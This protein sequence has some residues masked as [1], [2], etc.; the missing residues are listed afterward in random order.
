MERSRRQRLSELYGDPVGYSGTPKSTRL[1]REHPQHA[2]SSI[3]TLPKEAKQ[4]INPSKKVITTQQ[5]LISSNILDIGSQRAFVLALFVII[6]AYK[7][8]DLI[9][10][11][12]NL[13]ISSFLGLGF[14]NQHFHFAIKYL[15]YESAFFYFLPELKIPSLTFSKPIVTLQIILFFLINLFLA[16]DLSF[17]L[18]SI[19]FAAWKKFNSKDLTILGNPIDN[20][21]L[22]TASHFKGSHTIKILPENTIYL[23][24]FQDSFCLPNGVSKYQLNV[25]IRLNSTS[26]IDFL[27]VKFTDLETNTP[28]LLNYTKKDIKRFDNTNINTLYER[29]TVYGPSIHYINLPVKQT[30]LYEITQALDSKYLSLRNFR[31]SLIVPNCPTAEISNFA[32]LSDDKCIGDFYSVKFTVEGVPPLKLKYNKFVNREVQVFSDQSLQP[33]FYQSPLIGHGGSKVFTKEQ[34]AN[35]SWAKTRSVEV[36]F[37]SPVNVLGDYSFRIEEIVDGLGNMVNFTETLDDDDELFRQYNLLQSFYSHDLPKVHLE[38]RVN[39]NTATKRS[40][41]LGIDQAPEDSSPYEAQIKFVSDDESETKIFTHTFE[42]ANDEYKVEKPGTYTL[43]SVKSKHCRCVISGRSSASLS[44]PVVPKLH[45]NS[46]PIT[47]SCVGQVGLV[48][49]MSFIGTPPFTLKQDVYK[50]IDG[51]RQHSHSTKLTSQGTRYRFNYEPS[52]EGNYEITF[53]SLVDSLYSDPIE[54]SPSKDYTFTTSMR[55]KPSAEIYNYQPPR[56]LCLGSSARIPILLKGEAPFSLE[57]DLIETQ[58]NKR[59]PNSIKDIKNSH[60]EIVTQ[61]FK[62]GGE[63]IVSLTSVEDNSGCL[64][65][66]N[67]GDAKITVRREVPSVGFGVTDGLNKIKIKKGDTVELPLRLLGEGSFHVEYDFYD[68]DGNFV[69]T[70]SKHFQ[71]TYKTGIEV[72]EAGIFKLK[73][74]K[75]SQCQG[76]IDYADTFEINYNPIPSISISEHSDIQALA[77]GVFGKKDV[78]QY[79]E[80]SIDLSLHGSPP[81]VVEYTVLSP[82]GARSSKSLSVATKFASLR[83][84]NVEYGDYVYFITNVYDALYSKQDLEKIHY[85]ID[86]VIVKQSVSPSPRGEFKN[87]RKS[88]RTCTTNLLEKNLLDPIKLSLQ[89]NSPYTVTFE[90]FHESSSKSEFVT[91]NN[92]DSSSDFKELYRGLKLGNHLVNIVK[93]VDST[94]CIQE[95]SPENNYISISITDTPKITQL[96][97]SMNYCVGDHI[98][99]Q[100]IGTPPFAVTYNF[101]GHTLKSV[102]S[103]SQFVRMAAEPG[104]ISIESLKDSA[105]NCVVNFTQPENHDQAERLAITVHPIPSVEVSQGDS[106]IQDIHEGDQA[107]IIFSFDGTPPFSLTY[108]RTEQVA[109]KRGKTKSQ[110]VE[111]HTVSDIYAYE[112]RVL[113]SLQGT[114]EAIEVSDAYCIARNE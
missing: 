42:N 80:D 58:T 62:V 4:P 99:Y 59:I 109:G 53:S 81:F 26:E 27:Q 56:A 88:Y 33:E 104:V 45:I 54:L 101:N 6:Q 19:L 2:R 94:E 44:L 36:E 78:C 51:K 77:K 57:Y 67:G 43:V 10:F 97:A 74:V 32:A 14:M 7:L 64:V 47:D 31:S 70:K 40:L 68:V 61:D 29:D 76:V 112:Y 11:K 110:V 75:D 84:M 35:L 1:A 8:Y 95:D 102:E 18:T 65:N 83:L 30:G 5:P 20:S 89:G 48:F 17:P 79:H 22:D 73:S 3:K 85:S 12:N 100:L 63:Y 38:E 16:S 52:V 9:L 91:L 114:Y 98:G 37:D 66:L 113:T 55:V 111:T 41:Y 49:D 86:E 72:S 96:D 24:P 69:T 82:N 71:N 107:E 34:L 105:S 46:K 93:I 92:V 23:N 103:S 90:I 13:P 60:Y 39:K 50:I 108:V 21:K 15:F 25:P 106:I 87:K 28:T